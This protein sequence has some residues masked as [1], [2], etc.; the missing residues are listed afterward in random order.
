[1][2]TFR[3]A[4]SI[5]LGLAI[6]LSCVAGMQV[7]VAAE[8][9]LALK[10][11]EAT[12]ENGVVTVPVVV[13]EG[14]PGFQALGVTVGYDANVLKLEEVVKNDNFSD[15]QNYLPDDGKLTDNGVIGN[16]EKNPI[17][18]MWS[19]SLVDA[20][21]TATGTIATLTFNVV[22]GKDVGT[23]NIDL[24]V[25]QAYNVAE[26][27][28]LS[29][30]TATDGVVNFPCKHANKTTTTVD[31]KCI[32]AGSTT[33]TC[34][35]CGETLSTQEIPIKEHDYTY[36]NNGDTHSAT[37]PN[38]CEGIASEVHTYV[39]GTCVCGAAEE[40]PCEHANTEWV[41]DVAAT[42]SA[43][44]KKH[45]VCNDCGET[46]QDNVQI[47]MQL[48]FA[49]GNLL[50]S[51]SIAVMYKVKTSYI[52]QYDEIYVDFLFK[53]EK[54]TVTEYEPD[55]EDP[56]K[57][58]VFYFKGTSPLTATATDV[59]N[60]TIYGIKDG[61]KYV[62]SSKLASVDYSIYAYCSN[63]I[64]NTPSVLNTTIV[65][66]LNYCTAYQQ[67]MGQTENLA[68]AWLSETQKSFATQEVRD[69]VG[70]RVGTVDG[71]IT[72][73]TVTWKSGSLELTSSVEIK[74]GI[75]A[76]D[77]TGLT[78]H[79]EAVDFETG[80]PTGDTWEITQDNSVWTWSTADNRTYVYFTGI[81][82]TQF[83]TPIRFT[84]M[85]D[86]VAVSKTTQYSVETYCQTVTDSSQYS[87]TLKELVK[88][89]MLY[90]DSAKKLF[91]N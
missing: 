88:Q 13:E 2:K 91:G 14:N 46:L 6:M 76:Q 68:N 43:Y 62:S 25:T 47:P 18:I 1:M 26:E 34:D 67:Y 55:P 38:G 50:L 21:I 71:S 9:T 3:K 31:A 29:I 82:A 73:P 66:M 11:G 90:G 44:G 59:I 58:V 52:E 17:T 12:I 35:D 10:V 24:E 27:D 60:G 42:T 45:Q 8:G 65:D 63:I 86:G 89:I 5:I 81:N 39:D 75:S 16:P 72:N 54:T 78:I 74:L 79:A 69:F 30:T 64:T 41:V 61:E 51:N 49:A 83:S 85:K 22:E 7:S 40:I 15:A 53:G 23:T 28:L 19:Y 84:V 36:T 80:E 57:F 87:A 33:V 77:L 32:A 20:D 70:Q 4:L 37:C 48:R 56:D